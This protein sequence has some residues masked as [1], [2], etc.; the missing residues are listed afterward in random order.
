MDCRN[1]ILFSFTFIFFNL[2][3]QFLAPLMQQNIMTYETYLHHTLHFLILKYE[4]WLKKFLIQFS[5][6]LSIVL[7][8]MTDQQAAL[9]SDIFF[10]FFLYG[11]KFNLDK[12]DVV[13]DKDV[14][15]HFHNK[16]IILSMSSYFCL[17]P[18]KEMNVL[19]WDFFIS[20][21]EVLSF[22]TEISMRVS[23]FH[24]V[25]TN[26]KKQNLVLRMRYQ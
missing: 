8:I 20:L 9:V 2:F 1:L 15:N 24:H 19:T 25:N 10:F 16:H 12:W 3:L 23:S 14:I 17:I 22:K 18:L 5:I 13:Y 11:V 7:K 21:T 6:L 26:W 4:N